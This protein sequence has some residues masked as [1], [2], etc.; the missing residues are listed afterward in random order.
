MGVA[1]C[2]FFLTTLTILS[3]NLRVKALDLFNNNY[4][5]KAG[6]TKKSFAFNKILIKKR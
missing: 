4:K 6:E 3:T 5:E 2:I 1:E